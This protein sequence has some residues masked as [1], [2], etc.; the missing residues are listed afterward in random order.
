MGGRLSLTLHAAVPVGA[1][2]GGEPA[3]WREA[4]G[5]GSASGRAAA[6]SRAGVCSRAAPAAAAGDLG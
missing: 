2:L 1:S 6:P 3:R 5:G 4:A